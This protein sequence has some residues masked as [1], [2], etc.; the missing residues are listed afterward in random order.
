M[1][2]A[3]KILGASGL[4]THSHFYYALGSTQITQYTVWS[5]KHK[6]L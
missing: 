5:T 2:I 1:T 3:T 6:M 4:F